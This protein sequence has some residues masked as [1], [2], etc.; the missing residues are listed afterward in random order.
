MN[1]MLF[2][3]YATRTPQLIG[4][5]LRGDCAVKTSLDPNIALLCMHPGNSVTHN[6][7]G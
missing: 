2:V 1:I 7:V 5:R 4:Q 3:S 6:Y